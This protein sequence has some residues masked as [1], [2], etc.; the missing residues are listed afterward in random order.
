MIL[1][2]IIDAEVNEKRKRAD[3]EQGKRVRFRRDDASRPYPTAPNQPNS[4]TPTPRSTSTPENVRMQEDEEQFDGVSHKGT[5]PSVVPDSAPRT[6]KQGKYRITSEVREEISIPEIGE[7]IMA[8]PVSLTLKEV[9]A[10]SND[11]SNWTME[12][13]R[14]RRRPVQS[15]D[16]APTTAGSQNSSATLTTSAPQL[17]VPLSPVSPVVAINSITTKPLYACPSA[18]AKVILEGDLKVH[19]LLDNGSEINLMPQRVFKH[20]DLPIDEDIQWRINTY[21]TES[22]TE[23]HGC[24][25]VCHSVSVDL[26]GVE[27]KVPIF[28][29]EECNQDLLLGRPWERYVRAVYINEDDGSYTV[30]VKSPDGRKIV[31]FC[32]AKADSDRNRE[33]ARLPEEGSV[34]SDPLKL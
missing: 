21:N 26:G 23:A 17:S 14:K 1:Q 12:A 32:A 22:E 11:I 24:L 8:M 9:L 27:A 5:T 4:T 29:V 18:R 16:Q 3:V 33:F 15:S 34:G 25:G 13:I 10:T 7:K 2:E 30:Q 6:D 19:A 28:V 31:R 20:L